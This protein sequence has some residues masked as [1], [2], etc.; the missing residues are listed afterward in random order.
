MDGS[1]AKKKVQKLCLAGV[2]ARAVKGIL[3][4]VWGLGPGI[5]FWFGV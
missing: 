5:G 2:F 4:L 1:Q 3:G